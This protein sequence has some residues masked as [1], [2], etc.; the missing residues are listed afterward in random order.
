MDTVDDKASNISIVIFLVAQFYLY[1][2]ISVF[3]N[4]QFKKIFLCTTRPCN[5]YYRVSI[6]KISNEIFI[7]TICD[8]VI[9]NVTYLWI[10][11]FFILKKRLIIDNYYR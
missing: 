8:V 5:V 2:K 1:L 10:T 7:F 3:K 9:V 6:Y 4:T 11:C